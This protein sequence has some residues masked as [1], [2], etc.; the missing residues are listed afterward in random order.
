MQ[1]A[2]DMNNKYKCLVGK[3]AGKNFKQEDLIEMDPK[4]IGYD[5]MDWVNI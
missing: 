5:G 3:S 2:W 1:Q 4:E